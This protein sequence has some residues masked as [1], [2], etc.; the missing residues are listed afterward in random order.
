MYLAKEGRSLTSC[1]IVVYIVL[2]YDMRPT[3]QVP[4][5]HTRQ[6]HMSVLLLRDYRCG[7]LPVLVGVDAE[8]PVSI[9][10]AVAVAVGA[11]VNAAANVP[12]LNIV[13]SKLQA[14]RRFADFDMGDSLKPATTQAPVY[15]GGVFHPTR[16]GQSNL[17]C[18]SNRCIIIQF[19]ICTSPMYCRIEIQT[20]EDDMHH[21]KYSSTSLLI[22]AN[23][24]IYP[25]SNV[26]EGMFPNTKTRTFRFVADTFRSMS[27][28]H[29]D[30]QHS[31]NAFPFLRS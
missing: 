3:M 21:W 9:V 1:D 28:Y 16:T 6:A 27:T 13:L 29:S 8:V 17:D 26:R 4:T 10:V 19:E 14:C 12:P 7:P 5:A 31:M 20:F 18:A 15:V 23:L 25:T 30:A 22:P 24:S 11:P 2:L